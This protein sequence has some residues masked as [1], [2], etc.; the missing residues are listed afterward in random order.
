MS[1]T[2]SARRLITTLQRCRKSR[3]RLANSTLAVL[4]ISVLASSGLPLNAQYIGDQIMG[5]AGLQAGT[6]P[7]TGIYVVLPLYF[8]E[9]DISIN[10]PQGNQGLKNLG[11]NIDAI[12]T[13]AVE[14]ITPFKILGA[15][16]GAA[17]TQFLI[18]GLLNVAATNFQT[19]TGYGFGDLYV[20]P[21]ILGWHFPHAQVTAGYAFFAPTG[22]GT[23]GQHMWVNEIDFGWTLYPGA[24]KKWN[25]STMMYYD[26]NRKKNNADIKVG[27]ILTLAGGVGRSFLKGAG[28]V[29]V[30]Y[31]A[32]WKITH[33]SGSDIPPSLPITNGRVFG[34]GPEI[35]LPVFAKGLNVGLV[36]FRYMWLLGPKTALGGQ[37]LSVSFTFARI[38]PPK[39]AVKDS[40]QQP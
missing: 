17:Y 23:S 11:L 39:K 38:I 27:D 33:D 25:L 8:R 34:V 24:G 16:Y 13:P 26:F 9:S 35:G 30:A 36:S 15:N 10:G 20:Q 4:A 3:G 32:Q 29:G 22:A 37:T 18:D 7:G 1:F 12:V 6:Q 21:L 2:Q 19:S 5:L 28:N 31:G 40:T 14:V